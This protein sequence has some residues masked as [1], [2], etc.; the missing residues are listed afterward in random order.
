MNKVMKKLLAKTNKSNGCWIYV[1]QAKSRYAE[2][3]INNVRLGIH[4]WSYIHHHGEI[5]NGYEVDHKCRNT[6]CWN[7]EHLQ[8]LPR[9]ENAR[10]N[11]HAEANAAKTHCVHGHALT[12]ENT[13]VYDGH[14]RCKKCRSEVSY[15]QY[16]KNKLGAPK[17]TF[18]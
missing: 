2:V 16:L 9:S 8:V 5:P 4:R 7:P 10:R 3:K 6:K 18:A 17:C 14:R 13:Y 1:G 12:A 15:R 11:K